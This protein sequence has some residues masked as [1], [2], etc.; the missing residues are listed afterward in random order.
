MIKKFE[1]KVFTIP[2][3]KGL[4]PKS[5]GEHLKLYAGYVKHANLILEKLEEMK[6]DSEKNAYAMGEIMRRFGFEF[7]GMRNHEVY[8]AS[9]EGGPKPVLG[10][11]ALKVAI[12]AE[13]GSFDGWL[14]SFKALGLTRG[15]G[16]AM[17]YY[18]RSSGRLINAWIDEQ[19]LG[20]LQNCALVLGLDMWEHSFVADYQPSG[21]KQYVED[22]FANLNWEVIEK[23]FAEA[24]K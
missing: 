12:E 14:T 2:T 19:H 15:I 20:Q 18:D 16:W 4:T 6:A 23:N 24:T 17:L 13:W 5:I 21:K 11:S 9:F 10:T 22:F 7:N 3:L 1:E 8:F